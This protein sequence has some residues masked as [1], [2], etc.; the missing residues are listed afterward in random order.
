[1]KRTIEYIDDTYVVTQTPNFIERLFGVK[2]KVDRYRWQGGAFVHFPHIKVF[3]HESG[4]ALNW[5]DPLTIVLNSEE[6]NRENR[7]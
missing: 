3:Y 6:N 7:F 2:Q 4:R 1:M 5:D